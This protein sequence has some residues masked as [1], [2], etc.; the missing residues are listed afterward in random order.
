[1]PFEVSKKRS[2]ATWELYMSFPTFLTL[3]RL[4]FSPLVLPFCVVY[5][6]SYNNFFINIALALLFVALSVTDLLDG[7]F[8][9]RNN[10]VTALGA[11]LDQMA[12]KFLSYSVLIA[13]V[14]VHKIYF[15][16]AVL[17]IGREFFMCMLRISALEQGYAISV[18]IFG[19]LKTVV[20]TIFITIAILHPGHDQ[21][22]SLV[23]WDRA[24]LATLIATFVFSFGS[25]VLYALDYGVVYKQNKE[26]EQV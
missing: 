6:S 13:L 25:A 12:D 21:I 26:K 7:Y 20:Q 17:L 16:W 2:R 5:G 10:T 15:Y 18:S 23:Q 3:F 1:M 14:A 8:A 11:L 9:R 24:Y 4:I 22:I 19:K